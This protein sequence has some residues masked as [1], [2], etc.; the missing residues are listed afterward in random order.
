[1]TPAMADDPTL[2]G[3]TKGLIGDEIRPLADLVAAAKARGVAVE[4]VIS[5]YYPRFAAHINTPFLQPLK[6]KVEA[7]TGLPVRD[8]STA[9]ASQAEFGDYQHPNKNGSLRYIGQ[10]VNDG[11][12]KA[13]TNSSLSQ[14]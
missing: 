13:A 1:M 7:A 3:F 5:P 12:F 2:G 14:K 9:L 11:I 8:Y 6:E 4:L 10:L